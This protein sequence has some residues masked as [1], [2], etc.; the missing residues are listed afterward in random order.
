LSISNKEK[1][2]HSAIQSS[3]IVYIATGVLRHCDELMKKND[4]EKILELKD[5][6]GRVENYMASVTRRHSAFM[7]FM[8]TFVVLIGYGGWIL[9]WSSSPLETVSESLKIVFSIIFYLGMAA[10]LAFV[11]HRLFGP[12]YKHVETMIEEK[13]TW[14]TKGRR[15]DR[16]MATIWIVFGVWIFAGGFLLQSTYGTIAWAYVIYGGL[17]IAVFAIYILDSV[18]FGS[19]NRSLE[20]LISAILLWILSPIIF[21]ES[22]GD[23][24][25]H[26]TYAISVSYLCAGLYALYTAEKYAILA[27]AQ[28]G[29]K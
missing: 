15:F 28:S 25:W 3:S 19:W 13:E 24:W 18:I 8:W 12:R 16:W 1:P 23:M 22:T 14:Q 20:H 11:G 27:D 7:Y 5:T 6:L 10:L 21:F 2:T 17:S 9:I 4:I 29:G 26:F